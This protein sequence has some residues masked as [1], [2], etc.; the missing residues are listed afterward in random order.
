MCEL[1]RNARPSYR[2][3]R[4]D[5]SLAQA[6][7][8]KMSL[9]YFRLYPTDYEAKTSHLTILEDGAYS[10]LLRLCWMTPGCSLPDD[11]EWIMRRVRARTPEEVEAVKLVLTE[12]F[13][14]EK[15]RVFN[16]RILEEYQHSSSRHA[17]ASKNGKKGGRPAKSPKTKEKD[18][19]YGLAN[20]KLTGKLKKANQNQNQNHNNP[21][22]PKGD[23]DA[24]WD[25]CPRKVGKAA[26]RKSYDKAVKTVDPQKIA[27]AMQAFAKSQAGKDPQYIPHPSTWLNAGR[28]DDDVQSD[29]GNRVSDHPEHGDVIKAPNGRWREYVHGVGWCNLRPDEARERGLE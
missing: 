8:A 16:K 13:S 23:F 12:Y 3:S 1:S 6:K 4:I 18:E 22:T 10:R 27:D 29:G 2:M 11:E 21:Q 20:E 15:Q 26:A 5:A 19:S 7:R 14:R 17:A 25:L 24:F 9:P 28:W